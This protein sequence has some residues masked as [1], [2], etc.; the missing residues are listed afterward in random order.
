LKQGTFFP[1][2][3]QQ[4]LIEGSREGKT[5]SDRHLIGGEGNRL[6]SSAW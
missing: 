6:L 2:L 3:I 4:P 1:A 5:S